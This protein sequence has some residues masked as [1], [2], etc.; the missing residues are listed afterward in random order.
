MPT[1][2]PDASAAGSRF[3]ICEWYGEPFAAMESARREALAN[4]A[5]SPNEAPPPCPFQPNRPPCGKRGGVCSI[6]RYRRGQGDALGEA[7]A[8]PVITCPRR[9]EEDSLP[10]WWLGDI[11]GFEAGRVQVATEVGFM[12]GTE[13]GKPAGK[14][15][16]V[17]AEA[18]AL[19]EREVPPA[20]GSTRRGLRWFGLE[21]QAVY[22][23]GHGMRSEF[24]RLRDGGQA[25]F[26]NAIRRPDW[27]SSSAK[28][29]MPQLQIK[30]PT[31]RRW[32]AK[33]AVVVDRPFF[34]SVGGVSSEFSQDLGDGD[35]IW[36][37]VGMRSADA[38]HHRL[39]RH[40]WEVETL[41][42]SCDRLLAAKTVPQQTFLDLLRQK[43]RPIGA[44][45]S[46]GAEEPVGPRRK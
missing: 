16:M 12:Q 14:I 29:L 27:R 37:V 18:P 19:S 39:T 22:F 17:V 11:V 3:G 28:R 43:L 24:E 31:L 41:E 26:P 8:E 42:A 10:A 40:H 6:R 45:S 9:F 38:G 33:M 15:D 46:A 21:V 25:P 44:G 4:L 7:V 20:H 35:V 32:Q 2:N 36:M 13:T 5:L 30:V 1:E 34:E 23:S